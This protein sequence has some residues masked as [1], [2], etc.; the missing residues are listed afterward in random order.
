LVSNIDSKVIDGMSM[1]ADGVDVWWDVD[2]SDG[3]VITPDSA[4]MAVRLKEDD[5]VGSGTV[6]ADDM[7]P[8]LTRVAEHNGTDMALLK[9]TAADC[10]N[11]AESVGGGVEASTVT[12]LS[13]VASEERDGVGMS[14]DRLSAAV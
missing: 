8:D 13:P 12:R 9:R 1:S 11:S 14:A 7:T 10:L 2:D 3:P 6:M 4:I 5:S